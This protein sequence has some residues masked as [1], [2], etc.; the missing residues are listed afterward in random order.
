MFVAVGDAFD[1]DFVL[2]GEG[3]IERAMADRSPSVGR[4]ERRLSRTCVSKFG[5]SDAPGFG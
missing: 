5:R 3:D 4:Q 2:R 1:A